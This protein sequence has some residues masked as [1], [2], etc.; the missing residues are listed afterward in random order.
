MIF[1]GVQ[2]GSKDT[3]RRVPTRGPSVAAPKG[4]PSRSKTSEP[5][6]TPCRACPSM[7]YRSIFTKFARSSLQH[8]IAVYVQ[9]KAT[10]KKL[11]GFADEQHPGEEDLKVVDDGCLG[12]VDGQLQSN[13]TPLGIDSNEAVLTRIVDPI[14]NVVRRRIRIAYA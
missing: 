3:S 7:R 9:V 1:V 8:L 11:G 6:S 14:V 10:V 13:V 12:D 5:C 4:S 2:G